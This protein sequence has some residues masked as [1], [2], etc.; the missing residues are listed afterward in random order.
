MYE[1]PDDEKP[2]TVPPVMRATNNYHRQNSQNDN[3]QAKLGLD[4]HTSRPRTEN[5]YVSVY[6][7]QYESPS[8]SGTMYDEV[9]EAVQ[10]QGQRQVMSRGSIP[11]DEAPGV[12]H[13][14]DYIC[15]TP[16]SS[17]RYTND[18]ICAVTVAE[19]YAM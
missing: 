13:D 19:E 5:E 1:I 11:L 18:N 2:P 17:R 8:S 3:I 16:Q 14:T 7:E 6:N 9:P 12:P 4:T 10:G 15:M